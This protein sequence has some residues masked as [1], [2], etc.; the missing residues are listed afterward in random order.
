MAGDWIKMR[1]D[2]TDD[3]AVLRISIALGQDEYSTIGRLHKLW[4]WADRH[5]ADGITT[6]VDFNWVDRFVALTGFAA[7][8][9]AVNWLKFEEG[10]L[11]FPGFEIHNGV[12]AKS[13]CDAAIRQRQSRSR[14][15]GVTNGGDQRATLPKAFIRAVMQRDNYQCVYCGTA[16]TAEREAQRRPHL[17]VDHIVPF[18]RHGRQAIEDLATCCK[19]CN[20]E[21][22]DRTPQEWGILP[23]FLQDGLVF[24]DNAIVTADCDSVVTKPVTREEKRRE[25]LIEGTHTPC[26]YAKFDSVAADVGGI[27]IDGEMVTY[28]QD[29]IRWEAEF[30]RWW[31]RLRDATK[32]LSHQLDTQERRLLHARFEEPD[33]YWKRAGP[34]FPLWTSTGWR[35]TLLWF[36]EPGN[37]NKINAGKYTH[38]EEKPSERTNRPGKG[39]S[40]GG[41]AIGPGQLFVPGRADPTF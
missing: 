41:Q 11:S 33:W 24:R 21:K 18:S 34:R 25:E 27:E 26:T 37:V 17:S 38:T 14:H 2:L 1:T 8:L 22:A 4:S 30:I 12:S 36:L 35:P 40:R 23:D 6:G 3:P 39:N 15:K 31:N 9:E 32:H 13:R 5:T 16:S 29:W 10:V 19:L 20:G 28:S 7:E